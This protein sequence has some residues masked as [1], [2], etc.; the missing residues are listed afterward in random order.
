MMC[1]EMKWCMT[2]HFKYKFPW[3]V[4]VQIHPKVEGFRNSTYILPH[5]AAPSTHPDNF[6]EVLSW[7]LCSCCKPSAPSLAT[8][9]SSP[10]GWAAHSAQWWCPQRALARTHRHGPPWVETSSGRCLTPSQMWNQ[11][12]KWKNVKLWLTEECELILE[13][14]EAIMWSYVWWK[15]VVMT[16]ECGYNG[17][18]WGYNGRSGIKIEECEVRMKEVGG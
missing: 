7:A 15:N 13:E 3:T 4:S 12:G 11:S 18:M 14:C 8:F 5:H 16:E 6:P 17:R 10:S 2:N 9:S 1:G